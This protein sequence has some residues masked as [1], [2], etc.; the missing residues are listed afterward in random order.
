MFTVV[1]SLYRHLACLL[2]TPLEPHRRCASRYVAD[3][4]RNVRDGIAVA[5][6]AEPVLIYLCSRNGKSQK[7]KQYLNLNLMLVFE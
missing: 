4:T 3:R 6:V 7:T 2:F 1:R 5:L